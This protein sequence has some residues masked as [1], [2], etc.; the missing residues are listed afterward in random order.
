MLSFDQKYFNINT[1]FFGAWSK[2]SWATDDWG[3]GLNKSRI[4]KLA[5][6][7]ETIYVSYGG[8]KQLYTIKAKKV[9]TFPV[10]DINGYN[11][12]VYIL[13]RSKLNYCKRKKEDIKLEELCKSGAFG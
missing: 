10:E 8:K 7:N 13:P 6:S 4:D 11:V 1:P 3:I 5:E 9:Q 12:K 2:Y